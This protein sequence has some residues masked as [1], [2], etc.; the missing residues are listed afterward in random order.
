M[1]FSAR[2][3]SQAPARRAACIGAAVLAAV[4]VVT[5]ARV[6]SAQHPVVD[7]AQDPTWSRSSDA[8][9]TLFPDGEIYPVYVA[10]PHRPTNV[11]AA[12]FV[13]GEGIPA[14]RSPLWRLG[15][16]GRFGMLRIAPGEPGGRAWQISIDAGLDAVFDSQNRAEVVGWDGNYGLTVTTASGGAVALKIA[17]LHVSAHVGDEHRERT[18]RVGAVPLVGPGRPQLAGR[19]AGDRP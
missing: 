2:R 16:G 8:R 5:S 15:A 18:G 14:S 11:I 9:L 17:V 1:R 13:I 6:T 19:L 7:H 10:D 3:S 4:A 12:A